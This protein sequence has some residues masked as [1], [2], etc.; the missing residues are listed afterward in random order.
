[1]FTPIVTPTTPLRQ[2]KKR[3]YFLMSALACA[4]ALPL[5]GQAPGQN[6]MG[7]Q[8]SM[9][10]QNS[11][12]KQ[13]KF[14]PFNPSP[15]QTDPSQQQMEDERARMRNADRQ[16]HLVNDTQKLLQLATELKTDVDK[17]NKNILSIDVIKKADEIE[18]LAHSVKEKMKA[19]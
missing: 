18:R 8:S 14:D 15:A 7:S 12:T 2:R 1:M 11:G 17:T 19:D 5:T 13:G 4:V 10:G 9:N 6:G 3:S 16:K